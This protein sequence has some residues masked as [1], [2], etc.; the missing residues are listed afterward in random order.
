[1]KNRLSALALL[2]GLAPAYNLYWAN[3][4]SHTGY[5]DGAST[6]RHAFAY[7]RDTALIQVLAVTDHCGGLRLDSLR[8]PELKAQADS[9]TVPGSFVGVA[10]YEWSIA[11]RGH[12]NVFF[13]DSLTDEVACPTVNSLYDWMYLQPTA[14]AQFNHPI[15]GNYRSFAYSDSGDA[16]VAL[17]EMQDSNQAERY[18]IALDNGWHVGMAA[19]QDNHHANWG[20]GN[21]LTGIW[22]DSLTRPSVHAAIRAMRTFGTLDRNLTLSLFANDSWMGTTIE[23]GKIHFRVEASDPDSL[24]RIAQLAIITNGGVVLDSLV[25]G[26]TNQ[27][28]WECS[29]ATS[30]AERRYYYCRA[31]E[32]DRDR[33]QTSAVWTV[34][35][36][37]VESGTRGARRPRIVPNPFR[38]SAVVAGNEVA[39]LRVCDAAG[40]TI[41]ELRGDRFGVELAPGVYFVSAA[42]SPSLCSRVVK[43]R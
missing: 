28:V 19:N 16:S 21:A 9:A 31:I 5:S 10:G 34:A 40:R 23:N 36:T 25:V 24:D 12:V 20:A 22:A 29:T 38:S 41:G 11:C 39:I 43:I 32:V 6:S 8:W 37:G 18:H 15:P 4:H 13:A 42:A 14:L 26:D 3:L 7:A 27:A 2:A 33:A 30:Y 17:F 1:M 35:R